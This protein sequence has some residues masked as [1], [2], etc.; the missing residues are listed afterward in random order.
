MAFECIDVGGPE[1]TELGQPR[2]NFLERSGF[3]PVETSLC[4]HGGFDETGLPQ[5][6]QVLGYR[7]LWHPELTLNLAY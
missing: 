2:I 4:I 1:A 7:R 5:H 3:Q 6:S